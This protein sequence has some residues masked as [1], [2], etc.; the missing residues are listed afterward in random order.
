MR[1]VARADRDRMNNNNMHAGVPPG[2]FSDG[3]EEPPAHLAG[4]GS[5]VDTLSE[6]KP[7]SVMVKHNMLNRTRE[8]GENNTSIVGE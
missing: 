5:G 2:G 8:G 3:Q 1:D 7:V 6:N 4:D